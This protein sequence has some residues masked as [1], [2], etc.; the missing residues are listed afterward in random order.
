M[1]QFMVSRPLPLGILAGWLLGDPLTGL[2]VGVLLELLFLGS[3]PIGA[4]RLP[5]PGPAT[6]P[7]VTAAVL[8]GG[9]GGLLLAIVWGVL[10][11]GLGGYTVTLLRSWNA[12]T[13]RGMERGDWTVSRLSRAHFRC[14][15]VDALRGM[16]LVAVGLLLLVQLP[17]SWVLRIPLSEGEVVGWVGVAG[18]LSLGRVVQGYWGASPARA[19]VLLGG[20]LGVGIALALAFW[21]GRP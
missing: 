20:G 3:L 12:W 18:G 4:A 14:L 2:Q 7:A 8:Y 5:E 1:G 16:G 15:G 6:L 9:G 21:G 11:A 19:V 17:P 10:G 13:T